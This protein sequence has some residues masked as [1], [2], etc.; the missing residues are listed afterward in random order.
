MDLHAPQNVIPRTL[1]KTLDSVRLPWPEL[2]GDITQLAEL[3]V[4]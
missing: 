4:I 1:L 2:L 3:I